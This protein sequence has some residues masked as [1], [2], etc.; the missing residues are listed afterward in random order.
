MGVP[1]ID[2][3]GRIAIRPALE[4]KNNFKL[5]HYANCGQLDNP[6]PGRIFPHSVKNRWKHRWRIKK[7]TIQVT[8]S[9]FF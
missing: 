2:D 3:N 6:K 1:L 5:Y 7:Q 4:L 8:V 9:I